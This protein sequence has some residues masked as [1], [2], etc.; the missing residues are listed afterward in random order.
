MKK[1]SVSILLSIG[2]SMSSYAEK[3]NILIIY[4]KSTHQ[5]YAHNNEEIASLLKTKLEG[6]EY[7][8]R[9]DVE[10]TF[11]YPS[12]L[13]KV[14]DA[15]LVIISSDGGPKHAL[16]DKKDPTKHTKHFDS[17]IK[18]N[19]TGVIMV[20]WATDA[21][22]PVFG[23]LHKENGQM[24]QDWIGAVYYWVNKGKD[25]ASSWTWKFPVMEFEVN[26]E[27]PIANGLPDTFKLQDEYYYNFFTEGA[28]S[29]NPKN[30]RVTYIHSSKAPSVREDIED[31]SKWRV[32]P[33]YW[34]YDRE[35]GGRSVGLTSAHFY[36]TW[37]NPHFF[38]TFT[39]SI[40]WTLN[41]EVPAEGANIPT[42][43]LK[44]L[45]SVNKKAQIY[46]KAE[47]FK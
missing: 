24:M 21:P 7:A 42:P 22:S 38:K 31:T 41:E 4:G 16:F 17:V 2:L 6:S 47:H 28:D 26:K 9:F 12:D 30:D 19:Q 1:L 37:A 29:R 25:P 13:S 43:S 15:D 33:T 23:K 18:K 34:A 11:N 36:H 46:M 14:E 3:K 44:E 45:L 10:T 40:L 8:D 32:Q 39:N 35:D 27:H 5:N 20:H